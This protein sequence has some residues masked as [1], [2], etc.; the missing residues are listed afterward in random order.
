MFGHK[1]LF[2]F[3]RIITFYDL[4]IIFEAL[5]IQKAS[6]NCKKKCF[7]IQTLAIYKIY[8]VEASK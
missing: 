8:F 5:E 4:H 2:N 1:L 3:K 7:K 6:L